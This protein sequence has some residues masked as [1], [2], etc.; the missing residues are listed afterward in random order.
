MPV[1]IRKNCLSNKQKVGCKAIKPLQVNF[2]SFRDKV[3]DDDRN[4]NNVNKQMDGYSFSISPSIREI[5]NR[6]I[7]NAH[8]VNNIFVVMMQKV[9][10]KYIIANYI[11]LPYQV[12]TAKPTLKNR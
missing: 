2:L 11:S 4:K 1:V 7:P 3:C 9:N 10:L 5:I 8:P 12:L 6:H